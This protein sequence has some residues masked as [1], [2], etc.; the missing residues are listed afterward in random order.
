M[1]KSLPS[2]AANKEMVLT[3]SPIGLSCNNIAFTM[4]HARDINGFAISTTASNASLR[5]VG[6][7]F[8]VKMSP[9]TLLYTVNALISA[10]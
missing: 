9:A 8:I 7:D 6:T 1:P 10:L 3:E 5:K 4:I 2:A